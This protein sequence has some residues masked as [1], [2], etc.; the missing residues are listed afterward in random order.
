MG[1]VAKFFFILGILFMLSVG[2]LAAIVVPTRSEVV[3]ITKASTI[4][5]NSSVVLEADTFIFCGAYTFNYLEEKTMAI[6]VNITNSQS[7]A[8]QNIA[9]SISPQTNH[10][11]TLTDAETITL[12]AG[13]YTMEY[14]CTS[15]EFHAWSLKLYI[16]KPGLFRDTTNPAAST[17]D[18]TEQKWEDAFMWSIAVAVLG[19]LIFF[20]S[21]IALL[22][23]RG[24]SKKATITS[25]VTQYPTGSSY[26]KDIS[27][28]QEFSTTAQAQQQSNYWVCEYCN[29]INESVTNYCV[30]CNREKGT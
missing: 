22:P 26:H 2:V 8:K 20:I 9:L 18:A 13:N 12:T 19:F 3:W 7:L 27:S 25:S 24:A 28:T 29:T 23:N 30:I 11:E 5:T 1:K 6:S 16:I 17:R 21:G 10:V 4:E 14:S 15:D